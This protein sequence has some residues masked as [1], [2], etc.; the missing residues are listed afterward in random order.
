[1]LQLS[2]RPSWGAKPESISCVLSA[3]RGIFYL[4]DQLLG[5]SGGRAR[6][7]DGRCHDAGLAAYTTQ[8]D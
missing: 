2:L 4:T 8:H 1:M 6:F 3:R 5:A 7:P